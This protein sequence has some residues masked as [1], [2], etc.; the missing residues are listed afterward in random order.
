MTVPPN[1]VPADIEIERVARAP[2]R[3]SWGAI[4]AGLLIALV[5]QLVFTLAGAAVGLAAWDPNSGTA[6]GVGAAIWAIVS[7][8]VALYLGGATTGWAAGALTRPA[9][10]LHGTL[11]WAL[12]TLIMTWL[13]ASGIS[14]IA[15]TTFRVFGSVAGAATSAAA[16]GISAAASNVSLPGNVS[17]GDVRARIDSVLRETG[18]PQL[19]P[20]SIRARASR[21]ANTATQTSASNSDVL[22]ELG[23]LISGTASQIN[24]NDVINVIVARTGVTR[25]QAE[26]TA[27]RL[28]ALRQSATA[29]LDTLGNTLGRKAESAASATSSAL[30]WTLLG[31]GLSLA[32][33][34]LGAAS[35]A[36]SHPG[37]EPVSR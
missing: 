28:I 31:L 26:R 8:L 2:F 17:A 23:N 20:D 19:N 4:F 18:D 35:T 14:S 25:A 22:S 21:V 33:A 10:L 13:V 27:D 36:H 6:L 30:W 15:G 16:S 24:R 7:I 12:S 32:A 34:A 11:V 9:G 5:L 1:R 3:L 29:Q 37:A